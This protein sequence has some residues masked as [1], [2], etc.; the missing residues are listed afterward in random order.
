MNNLNKFVKAKSSVTISNNK[1]SS[2]VY[3]CIL[4][5]HLYYICFSVNEIE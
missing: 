1:T 4:I 5:K 2:V 3:C